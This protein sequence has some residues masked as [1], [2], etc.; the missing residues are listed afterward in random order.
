M[1]ML[2]FFYSLNHSGWDVCIR[3]VAHLDIIVRNG[4]VFVQVMV[5]DLS[6]RV[7][8]YP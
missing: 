6:D 1:F 5:Y 8:L 2:H 4:A 3:G 7:T